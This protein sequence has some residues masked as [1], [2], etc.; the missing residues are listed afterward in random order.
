M[1]IYER[2]RDFK[3]M[4]HEI[5]MSVIPLRFIK[6]IV[7]YLSD[8]S[9]IVLNEDD[10]KKADSGNSDLTTLIQS[11]KFIEM[12]T[13]LRIRINYELV[14]EDVGGEVAKILKNIH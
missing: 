2:D 11:Q 13:D 3:K 9:E 1:A 4:F 7:C 10:I 6:D 14:E 5:E 8:G 12:L